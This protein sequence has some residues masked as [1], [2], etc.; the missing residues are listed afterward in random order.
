V[1][2]FQNDTLYLD[3]SEDQNLFEHILPHRRYTYFDV[4]MGFAWSD[5]S[6]SYAGGDVATG[7]APHADTS[8]VMT[9]TNRD[10][11]VLQV[12]FWAWG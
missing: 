7:W 11:L 10:T 4:V 2:I 6:E 12:G 5:D 3:P 1:Y 8:K 9:Q